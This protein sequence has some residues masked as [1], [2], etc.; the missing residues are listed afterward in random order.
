MSSYSKA[1]QAAELLK[2]E[3]RRGDFLLT[4]PIQKLPLNQGM[5]PLEIREKSL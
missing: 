4:E 3:I 2:A 5:N 1:L